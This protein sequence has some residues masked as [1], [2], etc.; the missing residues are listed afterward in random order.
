MRLNSVILTNSMVF[1]AKRPTAPA[2]LALRRSYREEDTVTALKED[3]KN[4]CYICGSKGSTSLNVEHFD[5]HRNDL[6]KMYDWNNLFYA[7]GHCNSVKQ[8]TFSTVQSNLLN[9]TDPSQKVDYWIEY[10]IKY[11][12]KLKKTVEIKANL[13]LSSPGH[14]AQISNTVKLLN[15]VY[16]GSGTPLK[17]EEAT[18]LTVALQAEI[19]NFNSTLVEYKSATEPLIKARLKSELSDMVSSES[20][21]CAFKRWIIRDHGMSLEIPFKSPGNNPSRLIAITFGC[22]RSRQ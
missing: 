18:N 20:P 3:F 17:D 10:R 21:F 12:N 9:C 19:S 4:K 5:E 6:D 7:C 1:F 2:S 8:Q 13:P 11:D 15:R 14:S 16:N 22:P